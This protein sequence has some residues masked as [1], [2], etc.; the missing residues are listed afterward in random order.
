MEP[1]NQNNPAIPASHATI[2]TAF[3]AVRARLEAA[4]VHSKMVA[5]TN[6]ARPAD[7]WPNSLGMVTYRGEIPEG[8]NMPENLKPVGAMWLLK[9]RTG[10]F[11]RER[12]L[13]VDGHRT[14]RKLHFSFNEAADVG[15]LAAA[16]LEETNAIEKIVKVYESE[17][18]AR[19]QN[20]ESYFPNR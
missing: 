13:E 3:E 1:S 5:P 4:G 17:K 10:L 7:R 12:S 11:S 14:T 6:L 15:E 19:Q 18:K 8:E 9:I 16:I 2:F 20:V